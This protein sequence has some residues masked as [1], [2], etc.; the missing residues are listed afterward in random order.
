MTFVRTFELLRQLIRTC[1]NRSRDTLTLDDLGL[2][3]CRRCGSKRT[4]PQYRGQP[5]QCS[6]SMLKADAQTVCPPSGASQI[7][8][9][10]RHAA[11]ISGQTPAPA[12]Q[13]RVLRRASE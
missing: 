3:L 12:T 7:L 1:P 10:C 6:L 5:Y 8:S 11:R 13:A 2:D 9:M 4:C